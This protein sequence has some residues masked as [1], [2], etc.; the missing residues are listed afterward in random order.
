[1]K[2]LHCLTDGVIA[3]D[4]QSSVKFMNPVAETLTG[5]DAARAMGR[6]LSE[7]VSLLDE[8][9]KGPLTP[10]LGQAFESGSAILPR[11]AIRRREGRGDVSVDESAAPIRDDDERVLGGVVVLRD[12]GERKRME[13]ALLSS[14]ERFHSAFE[15]AAIG[16]ALVSTSGEILQANR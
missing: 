11:G 9:T 8:D 3:T 10:L 15:Q 5:F 12:V 14:E 16:M 2:T 4:P 13:E 6:A 1:A 7:V